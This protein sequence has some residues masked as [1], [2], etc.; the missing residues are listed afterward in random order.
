M[1]NKCIFCELSKRNVTSN[2]VY[3]SNSI[4]AFKDINPQAPI[5]II[6]IPKLHISSLSLVTKKHLKLLGRLQMIIARIAK[7]FDE[8]NN[9]FRIVNNCGIN[10]G[11]SVD[12]LHYHL[13]G[14]RSFMWPP[15]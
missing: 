3:N 9:G 5:H 13:L 11:Q 1:F 4:Y 8:L 2:T 12:H 10:A 7:Q 15:G 6:V 14:G